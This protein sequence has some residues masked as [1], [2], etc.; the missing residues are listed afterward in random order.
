M[1]RGS[2]GSPI[3]SNFLLA[4]AGVLVLAG[5]GIVAFLL[6]LKLDEQLHRHDME[7]DDAD[8][9]PTP[10]FGPRCAPLQHEWI[11]PPGRAGYCTRCGEPLDLRPIRTGGTDGWSTHSFTPPEGS[12]VV[13]A[14]PDLCQTCG[15]SGVKDGCFCPTCMVPTKERTWGRA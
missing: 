9:H 13:E 4:I 1:E 8:F 5:I 10:Q 15:G 2:A 3:L 11:L 14:K 12:A 6:L 7:S